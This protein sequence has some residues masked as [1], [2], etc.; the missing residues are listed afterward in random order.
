MG[1]PTTPPRQPRGP[2]LWAQWHPRPVSWIWTGPAPRLPPSTPALHGDHR[3]H[4]GKGWNPP[5]ACA[6]SAL[7][8]QASGSRGAFHPVRSRLLS[9]QQVWVSSCSSDLWADCR[10]P[11]LVPLYGI[12]PSPST[13]QGCARAPG[14][15]ARP[16]RAVTTRP[17]QAGVATSN[18]QPQKRWQPLPPTLP[19]CRLDPAAQDT[20]PE[21]RGEV[22]WGGRSWAWGSREAIRCKS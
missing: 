18:T 15:Q 17:Q 12:V 5:G 20:A 4:G 10:S 16:D 6:P 8:S 1:L 3:L 2:G 21:A 13:R 14:S 19:S 11:H 9:T 22:W 7:A